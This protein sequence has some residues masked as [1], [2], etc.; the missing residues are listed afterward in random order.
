METKDAILKLR[1]QHNLSQ[2]EMAERL[3]VTRQAVSRWETGETVPNTDTLIVIAKEFGVSVDE[4]LGAPALCQSCGMILFGDEV[5]G[6]E[7]DG[8]RTEE[9]CTHC[10]HNGAFRR[11]MTMEEAVSHNLEHLEEW[12]EESGLSL[13]PEEARTM[14]MEFLPTLKRWRAEA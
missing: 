1:R 2:N 13:S 3:F 11:Q 9:Y 4:L 10:Y 6:T 12:N 8:S 5:K 7:S 14:L